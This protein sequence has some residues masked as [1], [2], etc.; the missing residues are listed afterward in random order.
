MNDKK[1]I[2]FLIVFVVLLLGGS[3]V[4]LNSSSQPKKIEYSQAAKAEALETTF[5]WGEINYNSPKATK[6]FKIKNSGS[7][8]LQLNNVKTSCTCT[9]AQ[10][11]ING[12][13]S[14]LFSM[15]GS[16]NWLGEVQPGKEAE[17]VVVF[18]QAFH[19][20][21]GV[22]A[23]ERFITLETNDL[24]NKKLEFKLKGNVVKK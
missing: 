1:V 22:G 14:P 12:S 9:T 5:D 13:E 19:G 10:I 21:S 18:D 15:H 23:I 3:V 2:V 8:P 17:L 6:T 24:S 4:I 16:S 11:V 7:T 20:P